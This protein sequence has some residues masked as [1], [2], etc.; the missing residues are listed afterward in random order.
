[1]TVAAT[2]RKAGPYVGNGTTT[3]FAFSFKVFEAEDLV[4]ARTSDDGE[5]T[6][7]L[8]TDYSVSLN[9][10]QDNNPGGKITLV[11]PLE[12][13][14]LL[15]IV[16]GVTYD[17]LAI[18]TNKGGFYPETLNECYDKLTILCQQLLEEV[19]R[20]VKVDATDTLTPAELKK[21][22]LDAASQAFDVAMQQAQ[23][24]KDAAAAAKASEEKTAEYAEAATVIVPIKDEIKAVAG[25]VD[26]V[27]VVSENVDAVKTVSANVETITTVSQN[28]DDVHRAA[29]LLP[30]AD[31]IGSIKGHLDEVHKVGQD[32]LGINTADFDCGEIGDD[33]DTITTVTDG[34][35][36][37]VAEHIDDCV[38]PVGENIEAVELVAE[39]L[40]PINQVVEVMT[41][42]YEKIFEEGVP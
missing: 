21:K 7:A 14:E 32:L 2:T 35:I 20:A 24:A 1:M 38:H 4:V 11:S 42:D 33:L 12:E 5:V 28:M 25:A 13:G 41:T 29:E 30:H 36:K 31:D 27:T 37:K 16:S 34:Y 26:A 17:Q 10:D 40:D 8:N 19:S 22:L 6:L 39:N 18:F 9:S 3:E 15:A 23:I